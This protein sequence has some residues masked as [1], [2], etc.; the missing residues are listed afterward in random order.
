MKI[1]LLILAL[2]VSAMAMAASKFVS[3]ADMAAS[4][5]SSAITLAGK[6]GY[7]I[8][9]IY[10]GSPVGT[11]TIEASNDGTT[12]ETITGTSTAVSAAGSTLFNLSNV[13]Y[14]L[15]RLKYTRSS[16][17]GTLNAYASDKE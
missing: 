16:G 8:H 6:T 1:L 12:W 5:T 9:A 2:T 13:S 14:E 10:A 17:T 3:S 11:L 15:A 7:G 4:I